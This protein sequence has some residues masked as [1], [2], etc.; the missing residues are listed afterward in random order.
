MNKATDTLAFIGKGIEYKG[1]DIVIQLFKS[2][3]NGV[4][5]WLP[6]YRSR[7]IKLEKVQ[8]SFSSF[9]STFDFSSTCSSF[10][11]RFT[12]MLTGLVGLSYREKMDRL[13]S[14][15]R[16]AYFPSVEFYRC[17]FFKVCHV[18]HSPTVLPPSEIVVLVH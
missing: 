13:E 8:T 6:S 2:L 9:L 5:F 14:L 18:Q 16:L 10:L 11:N 4:Q 7:V 17:C 15:S 3:E 12:R 1:R